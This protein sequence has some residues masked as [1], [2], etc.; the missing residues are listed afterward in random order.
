LATFDK[1]AFQTSVTNRLP[2]LVA[3][4]NDGAT[5]SSGQWDEIGRAA[6]RMMFPAV[7]K[8]AEESNL[9]PSSGRVTVVDAINIHAVE[10][11]IDEVQYTIQW[12]VTSPTQVRVADSL[13]DDGHTVDVFYIAP[14]LYPES[15]SVTY[16]E[17]FM[18][19]LYLA[20]EI[21]LLEF[22]MSNRT[23]YKG[24]RPNENADTDTTELL[25]VHDQLLSRFERQVSE[26]GMMLP[27]LPVVAMP[28]VPL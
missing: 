20:A 2:T 28:G 4:A 27:G 24:Y 17:Q 18:D 12:E 22:V 21:V 5:L 19:L 7:Y 23:Q 9:V 11:T 25:N 15:G 14:I 6:F 26:R 8:V 1:S 16:A 10:T 3:R 13:E